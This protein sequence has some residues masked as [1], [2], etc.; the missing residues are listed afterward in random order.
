LKSLHK[1]QGAAIIIALFV[2]SLVSIASL[3]MMLRLNN[4]M[5]RTALML[6]TSQN[7][8][9][10]DGSVAWGM[11]QLNNNWKMKKKNQLVD[12]LP[13]QIKNSMGN[14]LIISRIDDAQGFFNLNNL[15]DTKSATDFARLIHAVQ[16]KIDFK[17]A[18]TLASCVVDWITNNNNY[19][20]NNSYY[21]TQDEPYR[22]PHRLMA[23]MSEL[24]LV[25][26]FNL[27]LF[28]LLK[29]FIIALPESTLIN[30]NSAKAA[31]FM[32]LSD[33]LSYDSAKN[34]LLHR[35][36]APFIS[37]QQ[38]MQLDIIKNNPIP[39]DKITVLSE[40]FLITTILKT[41]GHESTFYTLIKR[42]FKNN[43]PIETI[44]NQSKESL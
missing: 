16:P 12:L 35:M 44:L 3:Q 27:T 5:D 7:R 2:V 17:T 40:Y 31:V 20:E 15:T 9:Y 4:N 29:P 23:S 8:Y 43:Q 37:T 6:N 42:T 36:H 22:Q 33:T 11:E 28:N 34:I 26:G 13:I 24:A 32:S 1:Q 18:T 19:L 25:K 21:L 30:I 10:V 14:T 41:A 38:F 39:E